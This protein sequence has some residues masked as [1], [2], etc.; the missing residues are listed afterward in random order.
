[1]RDIQRHVHSVV[2][3]FRDVE[4]DIMA[5]RHFELSSDAVERRVDV[6]RWP[7]ERVEV[8]L[9]DFSS[10]L[11]SHVR[12]TQF[13]PRDH[14]SVSTLFAHSLFGLY[15]VVLPLE[16][17]HCFFVHHVISAGSDASFE[18]ELVPMHFREIDETFGL[19]RV[20]CD[21]LQRDH[22]FVHRAQD[23]S[24]PIPYRWLASSRISLNSRRHTAESRYTTLFAGP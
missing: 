2:F 23:F 6:E 10:H 12:G 18:Q 11:P 19:A 24:A 15:F 13:R 7:E 5:F 9:S 21:V 1:M 4:C 14:A 8:E 20:L 3:R 17:F 22:A 16:S